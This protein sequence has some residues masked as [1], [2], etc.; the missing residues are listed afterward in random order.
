MTHIK[1]VNEMAQPARR[2]NEGFGD[3]SYIEFFQLCTGMGELDKFDKLCPDLD[4]GEDDL[5]FAMSEIGID[6]MRKI[7]RQ[8]YWSIFDTYIKSLVDN[9]DITEEESEKIEMDYNPI[10]FHY[11]DEYFNTK[12]ELMAIIEKKRAEAI[13]Q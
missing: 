5:K 12:E 4:Y 7:A 1:R 13:Q 9:G 6:D 8:Y 3:D 10:E 11:E 2:I